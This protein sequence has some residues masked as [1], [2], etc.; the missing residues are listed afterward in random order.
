M[1]TPDPRLERRLPFAF[2]VPDGAFGDPRTRGEISLW[3]FCGKAVRTQSRA[4]FPD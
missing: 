4:E 2:E 3:R 1:T